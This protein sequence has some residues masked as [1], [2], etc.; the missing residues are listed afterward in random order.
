MRLITTDLYFIIFQKH[1][2][3]N[4]LEMIIRLVEG[5]IIMNTRIERKS[6]FPFLEIICIHH[7]TGRMVFFAQ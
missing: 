6:L 5:F 1:I 4:M 2:G 3:F 7:C